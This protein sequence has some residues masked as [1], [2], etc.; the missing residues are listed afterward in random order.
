MR[1]GLGPSIAVVRA[2]VPMKL[3]AVVPMETGAVLPREADAGAE[4]TA[5][6]LHGIA[7]RESLF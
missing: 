3:D 1:R 2:Y 7:S 5:F 4:G 6:L